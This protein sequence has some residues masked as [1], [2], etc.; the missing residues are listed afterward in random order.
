MNGC[1]DQIKMKSKVSPPHPIRQE[2]LDMCRSPQVSE[3]WIFTIKYC[4]FPRFMKVVSK[5][6]H[7]H[8]SSEIL[9]FRNLSCPAKVISSLIVGVKQWNEV[10]QFQIPIIEK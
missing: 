6:V 1:F 4:F 5:T 7:Q 8:L 10:S 9:A 2:K 3:C